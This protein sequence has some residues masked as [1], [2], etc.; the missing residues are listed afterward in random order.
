MTRLFAPIVALLSLL[1]TAPQACSIHDH[2]CQFQGIGRA[3]NFT[4]TQNSP[5]QVVIGSVGS[6]DVDFDNHVLLPDG[7]GPYIAST[8][9]YTPRSDQPYIGA[10]EQPRHIYPTQYQID[11]QNGT[12]QAA[13]SGDVTG[14]A[15]IPNPGGCTISTATYCEEVRI[16]GNIPDP[17][18]PEG[19]V[20]KQTNHLYNFP[21][22]PNPTIDIISYGAVT[23]QAYFKQE[24]HLGFSTDEVVFIGQTIRYSGIRA[25]TLSG[26]GDQGTEQTYYI[27]YDDFQAHAAGVVVHDEQRRRIAFTVYDVHFG[28]QTPDG[29][30]QYSAKNR[31]DTFEQF[32]RVYTHSTDADQPQITVDDTVTK[33]WDAWSGRYG[34]QTNEGYLSYQ[35]EQAELRQLAQ[36]QFERDLAR[37]CLNSTCS[38]LPDQSAWPGVDM[39]M[40]GLTEMTVASNIG[41]I[42]EGR[43]DQ[44]RTFID[45]D[46]ERYIYVD[47][48][49]PLYVKTGVHIRNLGEY[50]V[51]NPTDAGND[52]LDGTQL[53]LD[54]YSTGFAITGVGEPVSMLIDGAN[55]TIS[56]T[57]GLFAEREERQG[58]YLDASLTY[59]GIL[60][61]FAAGGTL[62]YADEVTGAV[63]NDALSIDQALDAADTFMRSD[64]PVK[65]HDSSSGIQFVQTYDSSMGTIT[66]RAGI[67][68]N[69]NSIHVQSNGPH[70]NLQTQVN[71]RTVEHGLLSDPHIPIDPMTLTNL[72]Y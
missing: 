40:G 17:G 45:I 21:N 11:F 60:V 42:T 27:G 18:T 2:N 39:A 22:D 14:G 66:R 10:S 59:G 38:N 71:G 50:V 23:G 5:T 46:G 48:D 1:G 13:Y 35:Q 9:G 29:V 28:H 72:D 49:A 37:G 31:K 24:S 56:G 70:L 3:V 58:Y 15:F 26:T 6:N 68:I 44:H 65:I 34:H 32:T 67:D 8:L 33:T 64:V 57:R 62:K 41:T 12:A 51:E 61:P 55:G 69:P 25:E 43:I 30:S 52:V 36:E 19:F 7:N 16:I 4:V 63:S 20:V 54:I 47:D 53:A